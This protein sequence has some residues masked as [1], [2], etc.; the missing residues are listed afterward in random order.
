MTERIA[1]SFLALL[2]SAE[3]AR[4]KER[5]EP[6]LAGIAAFWISFFSPESRALLAEY[7]ALKSA[8]AHDLLP[9]LQK[10]KKGSS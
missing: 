5:E 7:D 6:E 3:A 2:A 8:A 4:Q 9:A 10:L 1:P